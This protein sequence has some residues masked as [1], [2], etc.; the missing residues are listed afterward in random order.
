MAHYANSCKRGPS[1]TSV[2]SKLPGTRPDLATHYRVALV[3]VAGQIR[4]YYDIRTEE[5]LDE[6]LQSMRMVINRGY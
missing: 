3:D 4:G 1:S 6:L 2:L 5:G